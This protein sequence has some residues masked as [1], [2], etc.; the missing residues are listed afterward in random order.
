MRELDHDLSHWVAVSG[1]TGFIGRALCHHLVEQGYGII[2]LSRD[3]LR[4]KRQLGALSERRAVFCGYHQLAQITPATLINLAGANIAEKRWSDARKK[5]LL[6]SRL[7]TSRLLMAAATDHWRDQ[8]KLV[9][10]GS[11]VGYYGDRGEEI[12]EEGNGAGE[13]FA[14]R[15]C[16]R[17]EQSIPEAAHYRRVIIRLGIVLGPP[18]EGGALAA[19]KLPFQLGLGA[20]FGNGQHWQPW[21][22]RRDVIRAIEFLMD[23]TTMQGEF[24]LVAPTPA[25]NRDFTQAL[26]ASLSRPRFLRMPN[27][28]SQLLFGEMANLLTAS[29][30][31]VPTALQEANFQFEHTELTQALTW[32]LSKPQVKKGG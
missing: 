9:I 26:A 29:Q 23:H 12:L 22:S 24:N 10:S 31:A 21:V 15:L 18:A 11:A 1:A 2:V 8:L 3:P 25:R 28:V 16:Q 19:M 5:R 13:D 6:D 4:A 14:A 7:E 27:R 20:Q 32:A 30:R 17:W